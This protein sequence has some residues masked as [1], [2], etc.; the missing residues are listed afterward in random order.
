MQS[1]A[2]TA[3][4][5]AGIAACGS[6]DLQPIREPAPDAAITAADDAGH[7]DGGTTADASAPGGGRCKRGLAAHDVPSTAFAPT[8][9]SPG[10]SWWYDYGQTPGGAP[11]IE[12]VPMMWGSGSLTASIPSNSKYLLGF[13]EPNFTSQANL[14]AK[15]AAADWPAVEA[16]AAALNIPIVSPG[17]NFCPSGP[18][19]STGCTEPAVTDPYTYLKEFF[20]ACQGCKV[21][22]VAAHWYNCD[23][24]S[25]RAYL[26]GDADAGLEGFV[27][28]GK[29]L[30]LTEF[31]CDPSHTVAEQKEYMQAAVPYLE[32]NPHVTRY[33]WFSADPIPNA[34]LA[35]SDGSLTDLGATYVGLPANC[36]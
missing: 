6:V 29:P 36:P 2:V 16:K 28:F 11:E 31:S 9:T 19:A 14:T 32:S 17:V 25:L 34:E 15:Q 24:P 5:I 1:A 7:G 21:D 30:W 10:I 22:Y 8:A 35:N 26:E 12:F 4:A 13:N 23:V 18:D 3:L 33:A 27:Q 20:E